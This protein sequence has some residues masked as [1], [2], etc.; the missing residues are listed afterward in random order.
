MQTSQGRLKIPKVTS[1]FCRTCT[2][3]VF[4]N[5]DREWL[6]RRGEIMA[7]D[8]WKTWLVFV[9]EKFIV[10]PQTRPIFAKCQYL[11][12]CNLSMDEIWLR[13]GSLESFPNRS[14]R[15]AAFDCAS[16]FLNSTIMDEAIGFSIFV[17]VN[18]FMDYTSIPPAISVIFW[19]SICTALNLWTRWQREIS[20]IRICK[21]VHRLRG[22][23]YLT[24]F[25][26]A[27]YIKSEILR[28]C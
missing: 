15:S 25:V 2:Y 22:A 3:E 4:D 5:L 27:R 14:S 26:D 16:L 8:K 9:I 23:N 6:V 11:D 7:K 24:F 19:L 10:I 12:A 21:E 13:C 1:F 18:I 17:S 20:R 28:Q